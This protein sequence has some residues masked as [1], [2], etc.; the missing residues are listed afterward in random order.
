MSKV[1]VE[2][3]E[4]QNQ[5]PFLR[6]ILT[7]SLQKSG[8]TFDQAHDIANTI[9]D[10]IEDRPLVTTLDL[11]RLVIKHLKK[12]DADHAV[13]HYE[14]RNLPYML[15]VETDD[16]QYAAFSPSRYRTDLEAI[17]LTA[18]EALAIVDEVSAHLLRTRL[19]LPILRSFGT[20]FTLMTVSASVGLT[21]WTR[22]SFTQQET[23]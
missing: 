11:E 15:Q 16:G 17:G 18:E 14:N 8:L 13:S 23:D 1:L 22:S 4:D 21:F 5:T 19:E 3:P 10:E 7:R 6:G 20:L 12:A 2:N 9:R